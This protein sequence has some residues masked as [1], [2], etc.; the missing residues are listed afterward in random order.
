MVQRLGELL[1]HCRRQRLEEPPQRP[2]FPLAPQL[3][4]LWRPRP[5]GHDSPCPSRP[6]LPQPE[7]GRPLVRPL[8]ALLRYRQG[9]QHLDGPLR[10]PGSLA[11]NLPALGNSLGPG[12]RGG[13]ETYP[14]RFV[15]PLS[16]PM[17]R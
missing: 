4:I 11:G 17:A 3:R 9:G 2:G 6:H 12:R 16:P 10:P 5:C 8:G 14:D 7:A 13:G 1:R 15:A